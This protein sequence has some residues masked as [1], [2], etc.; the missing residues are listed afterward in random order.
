MLSK[1]EL[2]TAHTHTLPQINC[3]RLAMRA[4]R[5][6]VLVNHFNIFESLYDMLNMKYV[7]KTGRDGKKVGFD[8][9]VR[10]RSAPFPRPHCCPQ[11]CI[12]FKRRLASVIAARD[13]S[14]PSHVDNALNLFG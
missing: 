2:P 9:P 13:A 11:S 7:T 8:L 6:L 14:F 10:P 5:T 1:F 4:G 12:F 3:V